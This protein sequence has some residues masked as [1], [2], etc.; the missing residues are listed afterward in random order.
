MPTLSSGWIADELFTTLSYISWS[1]KPAR[2]RVPA[3]LRHTLPLTGRDTV[4]G[5]EEIELKESA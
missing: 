1:V 5:S 4:G 3:A 2:R